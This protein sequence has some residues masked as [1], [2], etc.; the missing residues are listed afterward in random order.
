[1]H[2]CS[3]DKVDARL[4]RLERRVYHTDQ[5]VFREGAS[6]TE[7]YVI[8]SG[9]VEIFKK[10][11]GVEA[12]LA[13][14]GP[15]AIFGEMALI[16]DQPRSASARARC[17]TVCY[18]IKEGDFRSHLDESGRFSDILV[19]V[20]A[21]NVRCSSDLLSAREAELVAR[22]R[23]LQQRAL[24]LDRQRQAIEAREAQVRDMETAQR[25]IPD[26]PVAGAA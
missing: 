17:E 18:V 25:D 12:S 10:R 11:D 14:L 24:I 4:E 16:T 13:L 5:L 26:Q 1:M 8:Q 9:G 22:E 7:V 15:N 20:L 23:E 19:R 21:A 2:R 3:E 6:A